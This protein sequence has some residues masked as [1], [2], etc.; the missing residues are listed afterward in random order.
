MSN[1]LS[2]EEIKRIRGSLPSET[3]S[4]W[5]KENCVIRLVDTALTLA[6]ELESCKQAGAS[7]RKAQG[8]TIVQLRAENEELKVKNELLVKQTWSLGTE[9]EELAEQVFDLKAE[10]E[11]LKAENGRLRKELSGD[12]PN[13]EN[14]GWYSAGD[15]DD[16][17]Q[18]QCEWCETV[19]YS[20]F[21]IARLKAEN[22]HLRQQNETV[23]LAM[24][25]LT[26]MNM[27]LEQENERLSRYER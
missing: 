23:E 22:E 27:K 11:E 10:N 25:E 2:V 8:D 6:E 26:N 12:C 15:L 13:C 19:P 21:N 17:E 7:E 9:T 1:K 14:V 4:A 20:K 3:S 5:P 16:P 24:I 18:V